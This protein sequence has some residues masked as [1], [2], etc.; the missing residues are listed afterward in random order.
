MP[1]P[2][3][4][5]VDT[6]EQRKPENQRDDQAEDFDLLTFGEARARLAEEIDAERN[7]LAALRAA[8][9][10]GSLLAASQA[11]LE[12]LS[13]GLQRNRAGR[14]T[15]ENTAEFFGHG[16]QPAQTATEEST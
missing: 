5:N 3:E 11:R 9:A 10:D 7:R 6:D 1:G 14:I 16:R 12:A 13:A 8:D 15:P 2:R 4:T